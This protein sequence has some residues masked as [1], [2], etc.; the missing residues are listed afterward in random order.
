MCPPWKLL[1]AAAQHPLAQRREA[2]P[3]IGLPLHYLQPVDMARDRPL[4]PGE[5]EPSFEGDFR[6]LREYQ[7]LRLPVVGAVL[8]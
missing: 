8:C 7:G 2:D 6:P 3:T 5:G 1:L 4:T